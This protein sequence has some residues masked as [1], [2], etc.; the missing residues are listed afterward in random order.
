MLRALAGVFLFCA[1]SCLET[2]LLR[3]EAFFLIV[4]LRGVLFVNG[5]GCRAL[6]LFLFGWD[7]SYLCAFACLRC[8]VAWMGRS[9]FVARRSVDGPVVDGLS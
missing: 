8:A 7:A 1:T 9:L 5:M 6:E 3:G 4:D 2:G